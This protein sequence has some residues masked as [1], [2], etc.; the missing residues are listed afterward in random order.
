MQ[1]KSET[2]EDFYNRYPAK[3]PAAYDP[4]KPSET[5]NFN[6]YRRDSCNR[7]APYNRRDYYKISLIRGQGNLY[8]ADKTIEIDR[9]ALV[10]FNPQ[11]PYAWEAI[12]DEQAGHFCLFTDGFINAKGNES[13]LDSP[14]FQVGCNPVFFLTPKQD[15]HIGELFEKMLCERDSD[16]AHKFELLRNYVNLVIHEALKIHPAE[17]HLP[18][19]A[20][21]RIA[22]LF[23]ELLERQF[24]V[25][26]IEHSLKLRTANDYAER[27]SIHPNHLNRAVKEITGKTT[28]D[29]ISERIVREARALLMHTD[30][31]VSQ[32]GYSLGFE[33]PAYFNNFFK[34]QTQATP[35][36]LRK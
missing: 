17:A 4:T 15:D 19:S 24:P 21:G 5:G 35:R 23:I 6:V 14:L 11:V 29:H 26:S 3:R 33:Y 28:T 10:F 32:I 36:S 1:P 22:S 13:I 34:K 25:D 2:L 18:T 12:S 20:S 27:L 7:Y 31:S 30:W 9:N 16:Y 8:F